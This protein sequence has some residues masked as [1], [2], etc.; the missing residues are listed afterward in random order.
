V[1]SS[2]RLEE[3]R[4]KSEADMDRKMSPFHGEADRFRF[5]RELRRNLRD[6]VKKCQ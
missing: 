6:S 5:D 4:Q 2:A 1:P 3:M